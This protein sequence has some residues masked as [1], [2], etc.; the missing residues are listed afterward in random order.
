MRKEIF[1]FTFPIPITVNGKDYKIIKEIFSLN[2]VNDQPILQDVILI[3]NENQTIAL[4]TLPEGI[5]TIGNINVEHLFLQMSDFHSKA[6]TIFKLTVWDD[7]E[8]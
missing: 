5:N 3:N 7:E 1:E 4:S 6:G 2:Q 8:R